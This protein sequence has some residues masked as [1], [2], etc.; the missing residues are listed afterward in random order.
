M[1]VHHLYRSKFLV[2]TLHEMGCSSCKEVLRFEKNAADSVAPDL[3]DIDLLD[4]SLL[5]A[6][7]NVD[8]NI[9]TIDGKGTFH[10]MGI[11]AALTPGQKKD[12][13]IPRRNVANL[14]FSVK[15]KIP[16]IKYQTIMFEQLPALISSDKTIDVLWELSLNF[17][18]ET[19]GWQGMM[20][21]IHQGLEHTGQSSITISPMTDLYS[22]DKT[23]IL[24][25]L[26]F[27]CD[28]ANKH[29][30]PSI[31]TFDQPLYWKAAE[32]IMYRKF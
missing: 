32:I 28:L 19:P 13:V 27:V 31:I 29:Q 9:L 4:T 30:V 1:Q 16:I 3:D 18:Q 8:H 26:H 17:K 5:S 10:G 7:D 11:I 22:G 14:D 23:C 24:S 12:H 20:H 21:I 25:T 15:S 2:D 6:G